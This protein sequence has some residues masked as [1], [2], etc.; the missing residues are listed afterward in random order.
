MFL[1]IHRPFEIWPLL[2]DLHV[3]RIYALG[4]M[5]AVLVYSDKRWIPNKQ[6]LAYAIFAAVVLFCWI[7]SPWAEKGQLVV[8]DYFKIMIFY[9][10]FM[11]VVH[12]EGQLRKLLLAFLAI[13]FLY[14]LHSLREY[15]G[16]RHTFRMGIAR[17]IGVDKS[18]G[19]PNSFGASIVYALPL[20]APFW[21]SNSSRT[22]KAFLAAYVG[23]SFLCIGL[24]G[25]RSS[26]VGLLLWC[27]L[28][29]LRSRR[30]WILALGSVVL[31]PVLFFALPP[32]LQNRFETIINPEV[33]PANAVVSGQDRIEGL[34]IGFELWG[35]N[36]VAGVGPGAWKPAT[37]RIIE[38][39]NLYGQIVGELGA[40][41]LLA[42]LGIVV[43]FCLNLRAIRKAYRA[44]P[45]WGQ[46]FLYHVNGAMGL[47]LVL[48][49]FEGNFG[50][51]LFRFTW[52]W[53]GGFV[54]ITRYCVEQRLNGAMIPAR[55]VDATPVHAF[56]WGY[57]Y[58]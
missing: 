28:T 10:L 31:A 23:L 21:L 45:D 51:N 46:D 1:F 11:A 42:F 47:A 8:E 53:Y 55:V 29:V 44:H 25:S 27:V 17:M 3:E 9:I 2:G 36:P 38:S 32:S 40:L 6:H 4:A 12:D 49:L 24:T 54:V 20:V 50:H 52:L 7:I 14:M 39:H 43:C 19:D 57:R 56:G 34:R 5:L 18:L 37:R 13:M 41:G 16:G 33:G 26:F 35:R 48:L 30:R 15:I 58:G 22:M